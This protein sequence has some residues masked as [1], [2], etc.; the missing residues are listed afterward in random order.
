MISNVHVDGFVSGNID[1]GGIFG[2]AGPFVTIKNSSADIVAMGNMNIGGLVG[3]AYWVDLKN[4]S[5]KGSLTGYQNIGG[6]VGRAEATIGN[7]LTSEA[8]I[9]SKISAGGIFGLFLGT[10]I[11]ERRISTPSANQSWIL[12]FLSQKSSCAIPDNSS[13]QKFQKPSYLFMTEDSR[14]III[15]S[16]IFSESDSGKWSNSTNFMQMY[17]ES[18]LSNVV[19]SGN[20]RCDSFCGGIIGRSEFFPTGIKGAIHSGRVFGS[21]KVG[22]IAGKYYSQSGAREVIISGLVNE[23]SAMPLFGVS[24]GILNDALIISSN[25]NANEQLIT[26]SAS[27]NR[28]PSNDSNPNR[29]KGIFP[30]GVFAWNGKY[31][32]S[33]GSNDIRKVKNH[34]NLE[35]LRTTC[36]SDRN[37][38][39]QENKPYRLP[40][41]QESEWWGDYLPPFQIGKPIAIKQGECINLIDH[42]TTLDKSIIEFHTDELIESTKIQGSYICVVGQGER[43]PKQI[44]LNARTKRGGNLW[45]K[46]TVLPSQ[47]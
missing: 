40:A 16:D 25:T 36:C 39:F 7:E 26:E 6:C 33:I 46:I 8:E 5:C 20:I 14:S 29:C 38:G 3:S 10:N 12:S 35:V 4:S 9:R 41:L 42:F 43:K 24:D 23:I 11:G 19:S 45:S 17:R 30:D 22:A 13:I 44:T 34:L 21:S 27:L 1:V 32:R 15:E 47:K 31:F 2:Q 28:C 18:S 37:Y